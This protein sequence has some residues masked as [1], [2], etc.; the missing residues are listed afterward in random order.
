METNWE[1]SRG[2]EKLIEK[3]KTVR[4]SQCTVLQ[5][6][7]LVW[8]EFLN[9]IIKNSFKKSGFTNDFDI[10]LETKLH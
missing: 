5:W 7:D 1:R 8:S 3:T 9:Q 4:H 6:L 2:K 10:A